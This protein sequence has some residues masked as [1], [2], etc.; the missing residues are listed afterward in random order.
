M[1]LS[2]HLLNVIDQE[3]SNHVE[4]GTLLQALLCPQWAAVPA[5]DRGSDTYAV[6]VS[7]SHIT[8]ADAQSYWS[9]KGDASS[10]LTPESS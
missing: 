10:I 9:T 8:D 7:S 3:L 6:I 4:G 2:R 5:Y 1:A